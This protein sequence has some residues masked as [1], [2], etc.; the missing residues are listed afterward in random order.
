MLLHLTAADTRATDMAA[1]VA[2]ASEPSLRQRIMTYQID[3]A[4]R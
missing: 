4:A 2:S 1:L 3:R